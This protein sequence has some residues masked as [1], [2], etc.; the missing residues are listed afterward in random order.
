MVHLNQTSFHAA[1]RKTDS[2]SAMGAVEL[3]RSAFWVLSYPMPAQ[4]LMLFHQALEVACKGLLQEV[5][6]L[7][8]ADKLEYM[9]SKWVVK[10]RLAAHRLGRNIKTDFDIDA[11]DPSRTCTFEEAWSRVREMST[12][13]S[14]KESGLDQLT[15]LRNRITHRGAE[16]DREFEY[17]QAI[18]KIVIPALE[19]FYYQCYGEL[20]LTA[21]LGEDLMR[22]LRVAQKY[23][24]AIEQDVRLPTQQLLHTFTCK[25][26]EDLACIIREAA[27][28]W[29]WG[30]E[31]AARMLAA[32]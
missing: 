3:L 32:A 15:K 25:Y 14:F 16:P 1:I 6:V 12:L 19:E 10:D 8:A 24:A 23:L 28:E 22:E 13:R 29:F 20:S 11:F 7:L 5:H 17:S 26:Q 9:L 4:A 2:P 27:E 31:I 30:G 21:L 18:L